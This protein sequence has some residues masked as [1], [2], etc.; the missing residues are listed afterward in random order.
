MDKKTSELLEAFDIADLS[1]LLLIAKKNIKFL[2]AVSS[3]VAMIVFFISLNLEKQYLSESTIVIAPDENKIININ[4]AY[5]TIQDR[6]RINNLIATLKSDEVIDFIVKDEKNQLEFKSLYSQLNKNVFSRIFKKKTNI[7]KAYIKSILTNNFNI[8]NLKSS[9]VLVLTFVSNNPKISQLALNNII[10]SYQRYEVDNKI[11]ITSYANTKVKERLKELKIQ[12]GIADKQLAQ[13]KKEHN[14]VDTGNVKELKIKEI[15]SISNNILLS[16]QEKQKHE[17]DLTAV[18]TA[19]GDMDILLSIKD[20][21]GRKEISNIKNNLTANENNIQSLLLIYTSEHPKVKQAYDL[22]GS[23]ELQLKNI[24]NDVIEKKVFELSYITNFIMSSNENLEKAKNELRETEEKEAGMLN[25]VREVDSSRKLY[26][27]FLQRQKETNEAQNLQ[28]SKLKIIEKPSLPDKPFT[29]KP[30]RNFIIAFMSSLAF[31]YALIFYREMN[32]TVIKTPEAIEHLGIPQ[33]GILPKVENIKKGYHILQNFLEDSES[34]FSEAIRSSRTIIEAKFK[35][36]KSY[37]ITSSNPSEGKTSFAFNLALSLEK[38]NKVLFVEADIRR[39]SVLNS[40]YKFD[41]EIF[42]L[43]EIIS[44]NA[45]LKDTIF[46]VPGTKL[47]IITSGAKRFD[48]SD[49]V[50]RE[51]I[52][53]FFDVLKEEYDYLIIDSPPVQPVS[54]TLILTQ[55]SDYNIF[56]IRSDSSKTLAF[57]SSIKKIQNVGAKIDGIVINDLDTSKDSYY[58]YN[59]NYNYSSSY[60]NKV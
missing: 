11:E 5:S 3:L 29:P 34:N 60:Y 28:I 52:K 27:T 8:K 57:M 1:F 13:Y 59:Y 14:L 39:P 42:G 47:E 16:K 50:S 58:N 9:D 55:A 45:S 6:N 38:N 26:E 19:D 30:K 53:K 36:N 31:F 40:F 41:K 48:M 25:F 32:S 23:L 4:E 33:I 51:Q 46:S 10:S 20:L 18:K 35:K 17:N 21:N 54:D 22:K 56:L 7:D 49:I 12:M 2:V 37:L 15:Q 43:G 44:S 24:V